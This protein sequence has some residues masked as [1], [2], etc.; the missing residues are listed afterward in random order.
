M[1]LRPEC[2]SF[3]GFAQITTPASTGSWQFIFSPV[4]LDHHSTCLF[5]GKNFKGKLLIQEKMLGICLLYDSKT[6][7]QNVWHVSFIPCPSLTPKAAHLTQDNLATL[8]KCSLESQRIYPVEVWKLF[9]QKTSSVLDQALD[10]FTTMVNP[11]TEYTLYWL[12]CC[13][14]SISD[15]LSPNPRAPTPATQIRQMLL[16]LWE[17]WN[18]SISPRHNYRVRISSATGSRKRSV[19]FW[20]HHP[21]T[22]YSA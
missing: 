8:L 10:V 5:F 15:N 20:P 6:S 9:F 12:F 18:L 13:A 16:R 19:R 2:V 7:F 3:Y 4:Q 11:I 14:T 17:R 22:S 21:Q 1:P